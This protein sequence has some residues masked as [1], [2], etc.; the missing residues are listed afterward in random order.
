[1]SFSFLVF[2]SVTLKS[3]TMEHVTSDFFFFVC[4]FFFKNFIEKYF[5]FVF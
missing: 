5:V 2:Y 3:I 1:M 4:V